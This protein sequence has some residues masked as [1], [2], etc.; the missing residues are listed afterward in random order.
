V[1]I[2]LTVSL[3]AGLIKKAE[4]FRAKDGKDHLSGGGWLAY[5]I[6]LRI[7]NVYRGAYLAFRLPFVVE[8]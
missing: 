2:Q 1:V 5:K 6:Q 4:G 8:G 3:P 7:L